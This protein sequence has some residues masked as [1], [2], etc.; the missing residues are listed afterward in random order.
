MSKYARIAVCLSA[1]LV[2]TGCSNGSEPVEVSDGIRKVV[3]ITTAACF[4]L[5]SCI[6][7]LCDGEASSSI[8]TPPIPAAATTVAFFAATSL[9]DIFAENLM[10]PDRPNE[11]AVRESVSPTHN[12]AS[13]FEMK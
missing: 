6:V 3:T 11:S 5:I 8:R 10:L 4:R 2:L 9:T 13:P 7:Y 1:V 12:P